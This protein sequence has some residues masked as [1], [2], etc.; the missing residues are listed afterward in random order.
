V[1]KSSSIKFEPP[2]PEPKQQAIEKM[3]CG[4]LNKCVLSFS[5]VFWQDS[6]FLGVAGEDSPFLI[7]NGHKVTGK[8]ILIFMFGGQSAWDVDQ[9]WNDEELVEECM[10]VLRK[11][12]KTPPPVPLDYV[13]TRW[14]Q[15]AYAKMSY[16]YVKPGVDGSQAHKALGDPIMS[17]EGKP[18]ILFAGEHTTPFHPST[19]HG[20]FLSG[21]REAYRLDLAL[22]PKL[23]NGVVF[24]PDNLYQK[25]FPLRKA[26]DTTTPSQ[27]VIEG[28]SGRISKLAYGDEAASGRRRRH[29]VMTLRKKKHVTPSAMSPVRHSSRTQQ[30]Q[31]QEH[32]QPS[33]KSQRKHKSPT[34]YHTSDDED[35][36]GEARP[37]PSRLATPQD[38]RTLGR[39]IYAY[40]AWQV[41]QTKVLPLFGS[42]KKPHALRQRYQQIRKSARRNDT[43]LL[44]ADWKVGN[45]KEITVPTAKERV[46][47]GARQSSRVQVSRSPL[48]V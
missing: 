30:A 18:V 3:G 32:L 46:C 22:E 25:T 16:S 12:S 33:R 28:A 36:N 5:D 17:K 38:E 20:A 43:K 19:I 14:G 48:D 44:L 31:E 47:E 42:T 13:V 11:V 34:P 26:K 40:Q 8:P 39:L 35:D 9:D 23:N 24:N 4:L 37:E 21:I 29:G 10:T 1:L 41:I 27:A 6:D 45:T 2:L 15:D 7:L